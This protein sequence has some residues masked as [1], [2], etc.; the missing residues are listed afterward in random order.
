MA[1]L[2][3]Y[4]QSQQS[5]INRIRSRHLGTAPAAIS[6]PRPPQVAPDPATILVHRCFATGESKPASCRCKERTTFYDAVLLVTDKKASWLGNNQR[7]IVIR[8]SKTSVTER[9]LLRKEGLKFQNSFLPVEAKIL[10]GFRRWL[11]RM[12]RGK[13]L[14]DLVL[15]W[16]DSLLKS[17]LRDPEIAIA[18]CPAFIA[19]N[20][21]ERDLIDPPKAYTKLI[22]WSTKWWDDVAGFH[23]LSAENGIYLKDAAQGCG[24]L[25]FGH[26]TADIDQIRA[27]C[28]VN[29]AATSDAERTTIG[30]ST[31]LQQSGHRKGTAANYR[32]N[33]ILDENGEGTGQFDFSTG[34]DPLAYLYE[35]DSAEDS[36]ESLS[37]GNPEQEL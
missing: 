28:I 16:N 5:Q 27:H 29:P 17:M 13:N 11:K 37:D 31:D 19:R 21:D 14:P 12:V 30:M 32:A 33:E 2:P 8:Q 6:D 3:Q 24:E 22:K 7:S 18:Q 15:T 9:E 4:P 10:D 20:I 36:C 35:D 34:A 1:S 25:G 23:G 26:D